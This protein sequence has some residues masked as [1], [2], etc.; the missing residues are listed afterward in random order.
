L[1]ATDPNLLVRAALA[2]FT[3][4]GIFIAPLIATG[5]LVPLL[6]TWMPPPSDGFFLYYPSWRQNLV[7]EA[8]FL[9]ESSDDSLARITA[10]V[11]YQTATAFSKVFRRHYGLSP[12]RYRAQKCRPRSS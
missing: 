9:L 8:A 7:D 11:G 1:L 4:C 3:C 5:H 12:G 6:E 2:S 10:Q